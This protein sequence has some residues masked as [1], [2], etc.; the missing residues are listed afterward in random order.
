MTDQHKEIVNVITDLTAAAVRATEVSL[1]PFMLSPLEYGILGK[2]VRGEANTVTELS[3]AFPVGT[4]AISRMVT[5]LVD[6]KLI[7]RQRL[8]SD[9]RTIRLMPTEQGIDLAH[10]LSERLE[11]DRDILMNALTDEERAAFTAT[12][13]KITAAFEAII[14]SH[15]GPKHTR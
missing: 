11:F 2:C 6:R 9:R 12:A 7:D 3:L 1:A 4:P 13:R 8:S 10:R 5:R 15:S 14:Q